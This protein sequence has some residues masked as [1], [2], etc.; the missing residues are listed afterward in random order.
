MDYKKF[1]G[2]G[3]L[4]EAEPVGDGGS[5]ADIDIHNITPKSLE[6]VPRLVQNFNNGIKVMDRF[7]K[8]AKNLRQYEFA[9]A[10]ANETMKYA[11]TTQRVELWW[12]TLANAYGARFTKES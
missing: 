3:L 5:E 4:G 7:L 2:G 12:K 6:K 10:L 9:F 1:G 11:N 8:L